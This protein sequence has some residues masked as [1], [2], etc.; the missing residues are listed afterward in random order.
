M[1]R[2]PIGRADLVRALGTLQPA[3]AASLD[4]IAHSLGF[5]FAKAVPEPAKTTTKSGP[6]TTGRAR[7]VEPAAAPSAVH[8]SAGE[9]PFHL[10][11]VRTSRRAA[12]GMWMPTAPALDEGAE[13]DELRK[14]PFEPLFVPVRS[15]ALVT[16]FLR[17]RASVGEI[18]V[19]RLIRLAVQLK[20]PRKL[21]QKRVPAISRA[22][23]LLI[24]TGEGML[25]FSR[26][27]EWFAAKAREVAGP[28]VLSIFRFAGSPAGGVWRE[29]TFQKK[30]Y[31]P[32]QAGT[33]VL[34]LTD[35]GIARPPHASWATE[36]EWAQFARLVAEAGCKLRVL[37]PYPKERWP[38]SLRKAIPIVEWDRSTSLA[39]ARGGLW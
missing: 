20:I 23:Q 35:L 9:R 18:D 13:D 28:D 4:G 3:G 16:A 12:S 29:G 34:V 31:S 7:I 14:P 22:I 17:T 19:E 15:R 10:T 21:P 25:P 32:P 30:V 8:Q 37:A 27:C 33:L 36:G 24:D 38:D 5:Q 1:K 6:A 39:A 26:D 11:K 2:G